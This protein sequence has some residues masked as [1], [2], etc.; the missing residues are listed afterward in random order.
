MLVQAMQVPSIPRHGR[1]HTLRILL[2]GMQ[3]RVKLDTE[4]V[5][6]SLSSSCQAQQSFA[7][8]GNQDPFLCMLGVFAFACPG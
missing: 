6:R 1:A 2:Q 7:R 3:R 5:E 8:S 4:G